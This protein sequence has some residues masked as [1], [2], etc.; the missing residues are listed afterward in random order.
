MRNI[1]RR[2][3]RRFMN[4]TSRCP[5][6]NRALKKLQITPARYILFPISLLDNVELRVNSIILLPTRLYFSLIFNNF[7]CS[8]SHFTQSQLETGDF[9]ML[10]F[11][12]KR[13]KQTICIKDHMKTLLK[14]QKS[15]LPHR[16]E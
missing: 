1:A 12:S 5:A 6:F 16:G 4:Q 11:P 15:W 14:T 7:A 3:P 13:G 10:K 2:P 8:W 9:Q